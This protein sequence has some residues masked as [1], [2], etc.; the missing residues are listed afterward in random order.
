MNMMLKL[1]E[2]YEKVQ[3][4]KKKLYKLHKNAQTMK[5]QYSWG[6][7]CNRGINMVK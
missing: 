7:G 5:T 4:P 2:F 3:K 6:F 1:G